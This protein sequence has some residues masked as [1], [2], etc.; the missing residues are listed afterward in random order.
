MSPERE[1]IAAVASG[2]GR[3]G[4]GIIRVSGA[5]APEIALAMTGLELRPRYATHVRFLGKDGEFLDEGYA[6]LFKGPGSFTGEDT[7]ELQGHGSPVGLELLLT[8]VLCHG[9]RLARPG[10]FCERAFLNGK[11]DLAQ[12]EAIADLIE[13]ATA[14]AARSALRTLQGELSRRVN[15]LV[16]TLVETRAALEATFDFPDEDIEF[17][18]DGA[19]RSRLE[20]LLEELQELLRQAERGRILKEG[21]RVVIAGPPNVGKSSLLNRLARHDC[22]IVTELPGTTR[23]P[24]HAD[25]ALEGALFRITDT[26]GLRS[27]DDRVEQEGIRRTRAALAEADLVL[28]VRDASDPVTEI[29]H[30]SITEFHAAT[31]IATVH[32][33]IDRVGLEPGVTEGPGHPEFFVSAKTG[34]GLE[35]LER[36]LKTS[37]GMDDAAEGSFSARRRHMEALERAAAALRAATT[38]RGLGR[39][40]I[41]EELRL[42][43]RCLGEITGEFSNE[44]LLGRIFSSFCIGK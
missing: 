22:A 3:G 32:N 35:L 29:D 24:V 14:R 5:L 36:V 41:A 37:A 17:L 10:E 33:K 44:D 20:R 16:A 38:G 13:S 43:Q 31:R 9:A 21:F 1:T 7:L 42:A 26:A 18:S 6:L 12:A 11:I 40:L 25:V 8:E 2:P 30:G 27:T 39:E 28:L 4:V 34:A 19:L 23:D 15:A